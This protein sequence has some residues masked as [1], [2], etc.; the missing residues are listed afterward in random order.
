[1]KYMRILM[2][3]YMGLLVSYT[4]APSSYASNVPEDV[5]TFAKGQ[6]LDEFKK[7]VL[8]DPMGYGYKNEEEVK[9][10]TLGPGFEVYLFDSE[11]FEKV[12]DSLIDVSKPTGQYDFIV[13]SG[14]VGKSFL[15]IEQFEGE[16][17]VVLAGGDASRLDASLNTMT[18]SLSTDVDTLNPVLIK[19]GNIRY[20]AVKINGKEVNIPDVPTEKK[21]LMG[22]M[23]NNQ[24]WDS[25]KTI[26]FLKDV[27][28]QGVDPEVDGAGGY[29][30]INSGT[31][32]N[33][34]MSITI[35]SLVIALVGSIVM[36]M[37]V[38]KKQSLK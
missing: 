33:N 9:S 38:R 24:L 27:Q 6:G 29:P 34:Y 5:Q 25:S 31:S 14:G 8:D 12:S 35:M 10:V 22:G 18:K 23:D 3:I 32:V 37:W 7:M 1:M 4:M 2:V 17:R 13:Q 16:F 36:Y 30:V 20:L 19:D 11:K 21:S 28:S 26:D 15:S